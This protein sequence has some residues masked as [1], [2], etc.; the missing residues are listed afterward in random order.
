MNRGV[1]CQQVMEALERIAPKRLAEEWDNPGLLVG[2]PAQEVHKLL[3]CLDT[4]R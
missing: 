3:T 4:K 2:S 1:K